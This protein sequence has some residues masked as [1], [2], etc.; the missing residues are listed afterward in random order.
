MAGEFKHFIE[1]PHMRLF[2]AELTE[3]QG[4]RN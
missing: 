4:I 2:D 3:T 1:N